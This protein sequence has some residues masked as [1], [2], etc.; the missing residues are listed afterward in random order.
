LKK[1]Y[2]HNIGSLLCTNSMKSK[3]SLCIEL[4]KINELYVVLTAPGTTKWRIVT[5]LH[6][7]YTL[8][9]DFETQWNPSFEKKQTPQ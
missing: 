8:I 9:R 7:V 6:L 1:N 2:N 3:S 5:L 4:K